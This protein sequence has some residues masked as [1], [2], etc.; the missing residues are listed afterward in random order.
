LS[1]FGYIVDDIRKFLYSLRSFRV[2]H[3]KRDANA[4]PHGLVKEAVTLV[5]DLIWLENIP[6]IIYVLYAGNV[7]SLCVEFY[8]N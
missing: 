6:P 5:I 2:V 7:L 4:A 3:V 8:F 1:R